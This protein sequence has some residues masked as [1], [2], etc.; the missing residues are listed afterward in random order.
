DGFDPDFLGR[1]ATPN[2]DALAEEGSLSIGSSTFQTA[3]NPAR[4]S[5]STGAYPDTHEN[6]AYYFD[7]AS[8]TA[9]GQERHLEAETIA[10][11]LA[12]QGRTV[13][14]V[15]WYMVH[16]RGTGYADPEHLYV[17]PEGDFGDRVDVAI[18][19]LNRRPVD[20]GGTQV[21]VPRIPDLLAVYGSDLDALAHSEGT[22]EPSIGA[23][24]AAMDADL[25]RLVQA[26]KDVGIHS[27]TAFILTSDHG[28]TSWNR[29][30][31]PQVL[32]AVSAAGY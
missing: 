15:Q 31:V 12:E 24:L 23:R 10:E 17:D 22:E 4:A 11:A 6:A 3:S 8:N 20:S 28:M 25:G 7:P 1:A 18:D 27:E 30:L 32:D 19:I 13:A 21:T 29:T 2:L 14:S 26:T 9:V 16:D 5:M